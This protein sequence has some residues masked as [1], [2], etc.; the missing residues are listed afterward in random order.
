[1]RTGEVEKGI[2]ILEKMYELEPVVLADSNS[3]R[4]LAALFFAH[5][6][7]KDFDKCREI[8]KQISEPDLRTWLLFSDIIL[9]EGSQVK[10][11]A[12]FGAGLEKFRQVDWEIEIDR[13]HLNDPIAQKEFLNLSER[14]V[15]A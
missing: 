5:Y 9:K 2:K 14:L 1:M 3:D 7:N 10:S 13:F 11:E 15:A 8:F 12:W 6:L 4:Q